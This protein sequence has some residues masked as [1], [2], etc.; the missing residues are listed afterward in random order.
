MSID[1]ETARRV[2]A[3]EGIPVGISSLWRANSTPFWAS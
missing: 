2:A 1:K 3:L